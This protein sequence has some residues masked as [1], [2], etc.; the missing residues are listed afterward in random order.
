[1]IIYEAGPFIKWARKQRGVSQDELAESAGVARVSI[2]RIESGKQTP[3][4]QTVD[5]L[6]Q[7][8]G[9]NPANLGIYLVSKEELEYQEAID[10]INEHLSYERVAE[11]QELIESLAA[12][13]KF[14][15]TSLNRQFLLLAR[16]LLARKDGE[17][18][19]E[20]TL[21]MLV[22]A[23]KINIPNFCEQKI[24][25]YFLSRYDLKIINMMGIIYSEEDNL[26]KAIKIM[27]AL[28]E[29]FDRNSSDKDHQ[30]KHLPLIITNLAKYLGMAGRHEEAL[31]ICDEGIEICRNTGFLFHLPSIAAGKA[32]NLHKLGREAESLELFD[33]VYKSLI[34][35]GRKGLAKEVKDYVQKELGGFIPD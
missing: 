35:H 9:Y 6:L 11:A 31:E 12:N 3:A 24:P 20:E 25:T 33:Q 32:F 2:S 29:N 16:A 23:I 4:K 34:L 15:N 10:K 7:K 22:E 28:K 18:G 17:G 27:A 1:M 8:L 19:A 13:E 5:L 30:G 21:G 14:L 26:D